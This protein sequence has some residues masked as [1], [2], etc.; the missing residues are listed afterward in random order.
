MKE[1]LKTRMKN[2]N[3]RFTNC[4][5]KC[6]ETKMKMQRR[7]SQA[8]LELCPVYKKGDKTECETA[9]LPY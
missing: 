6:A 4:F 8:Q 1:M 9:K 7:W 5:V 3:K 2:Y